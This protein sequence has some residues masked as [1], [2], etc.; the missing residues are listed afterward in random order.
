M[1]NYLL[2]TAVN[3]GVALL[4]GIVLAS[5]VGEAALARVRDRW[6]D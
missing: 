1:L 5:S 3:T 2:R 4:A 6:E